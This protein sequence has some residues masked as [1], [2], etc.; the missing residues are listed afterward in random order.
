M[1]ELFLPS[2]APR[3]GLAVISQSQHLLSYQ[4]LLARR[5]AVFL[6]VSLRMVPTKKL[7]GATHCKWISF[8]FKKM[9]VLGVELCAFVLLIIS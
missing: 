2:S 7:A 3:H 5:S 6:K 8:F 1:C 9:V 4:N